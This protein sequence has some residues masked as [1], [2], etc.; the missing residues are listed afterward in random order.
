VSDKKT[1]GD[2]APKKRFKKVTKE[3][4]ELVRVIDDEGP[5]K[6]DILERK[7]NIKKAREC[8]EDELIKPADEVA[9]RFGLS[10]D[11]KKVAEHT[12]KGEKVIIDTSK[13]AGDK[14]R[15]VVE[16]KEKKYDT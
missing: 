16:K 15:I 9:D 5:I 3:Q 7:E 2:E 6:R 8:V 13:K 4:K 1:Q 14:D 11:G 12:K 10:D